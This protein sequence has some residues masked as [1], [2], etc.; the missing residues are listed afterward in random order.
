MM[1]IEIVEN[2]IK[3]NVYFTN[4]IGI[5]T[6]KEGVGNQYDKFDEFRFDLNIWT[7]SSMKFEKDQ[8]KKVKTRTRSKKHN[9][10]IITYFH[11]TCSVFDGNM[12]RSNFKCVTK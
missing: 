8:I 10:N 12:N 5:Q 3:F 7:K 11:N 1:K 2:K 9:D 4:E 6:H